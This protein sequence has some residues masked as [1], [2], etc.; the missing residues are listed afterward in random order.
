MAATVAAT[1]PSPWRRRRE[2]SAVL[3]SRARTRW[4]R[5]TRSSAPRQAAWTAAGAPG[6]RGASAPGP[7][8]AASSGAPARLQSRHRLA[9]RLQSAR[10]QTCASAA[11]S[12]ARATKTASWR[13]G[14]NGASAPS[15][16]M[17]CRLVLVKS[18]RTARVPANGAPA[19]R[20]TLLC[21]WRRF[22]PVTAPGTCCRT[23][24]RL[25]TP[26]HPRSVASATSHRSIASSATGWCGPSVASRAMAA[27]AS[28]SARS[29]RKPGS[30]AASARGSRKRPAAARPKCACR[31]RTAS[32][33][34]GMS[35]AIARS[36][37]VSGPACA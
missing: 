36:V 13:S 22:D 33:A 1:A 26:R 34:R 7:A 8:A 14:A 5:A 32:G 6:T 29:S 12:I 10:P 15:L 30:V 25:V 2:A 16:A 24:R 9:A 3:R 11:S 27:S 35:G 19:A 17:V 18:C 21:R 28:A 23:A 20:K 37:T 31:P 4:R